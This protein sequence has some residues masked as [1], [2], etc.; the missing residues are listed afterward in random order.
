MHVDP[1]KRGNPNGGESE[2]TR[3]TNK[4]VRQEDSEITRNTNE[5]RITNELGSQ[6]ESE[7]TRITNKIVRQEDSEVTRLSLKNI[8]KSPISGIQEI[9]ASTR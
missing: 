5:I 7:N 2:N 3:I 1:T 6:E 9:N 8:V 4:I